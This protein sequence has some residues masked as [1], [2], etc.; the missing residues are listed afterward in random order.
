MGRGDDAELR[1]AADRP[2]PRRRACA[3]GTPT[4]TSTSTSS[5]ASR[6]PR[7]ATRTRRSSPRSPS[8]SAGSRTR[9]TWPCTSPGSRSPSG[10]SAC[11]RC[12]PGCSSRT[13]APRRTSARSSWPGC[14][15]A[16]DGRTEIVSCHDSFHGRT[17]GALSVTG[18]A[19]KREPFAPLPGPV[20]F[21]AFGDVDALRA[22]VGPQTA[23]VIVEPTLGEGGV[24]PPPGGLPRRRPHDLRPTPGAL[25]IVDEVQ[26]GIGRTG[27]WFASQ[28]EG[29][30]PDVITLAKGLGGGL[31][32]G[33]CL[34]IGAGR[35]AVRA[36][37]PRQ[38]VR[39]QPGRL[40]RRAR[41]A[42]DDRRRAPARPGQAGRRAPRARPRRARQPADRAAPRESGC[43]ARSRST[44]RPGAARSRRPLAIADCSSTRSSRTCSGWPRR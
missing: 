36:R 38:H 17:L 42:H 8:R 19:A 15:A 3:S 34:G 12:R 11:S 16:R 29:V 20:R 13:A 18:N 33:A 4:A 25:M 26:S 1:H 14:T 10:S 2:R 40:R 5:A 6:C 32:I 27:H 21:V 31:P 28:A 24:V 41:R 22:A 35:R 44:G 43:G 9:P 30:R 39:R 7:S 37:R 23:A